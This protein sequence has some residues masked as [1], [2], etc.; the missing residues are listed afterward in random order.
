M[1]AIGLSPFLMQPL[2]IMLDHY[3]MQTPTAEN[4]GNGAQR[5]DD[6]WSAVGDRE[7]RQSEVN[8]SVRSG[9]K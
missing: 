6:F 2:D 7:I 4:Q 3:L 5:S 8:W 1:P 9:G